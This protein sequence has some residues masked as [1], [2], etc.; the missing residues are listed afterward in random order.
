[1]KKLTKLLSVFVISG[2]VGTSVVA[3]ACNT[4]THNYTYE[5]NGNG[6]HT[7]TCVD[8]DDTIPD[9]LHVDGDSDNKCDNCGA[10]IKEQGTT[11]VVEDKVTGVSISGGKE[12]A[13]KGTLQLTAT[14][15]VTG[16]AATT[17]TW[18]S[19]DEDTA[20]VDANGLVTGVKEGEVTITATSIDDNTKKAEHK[21][22]VK[23]EGTVIVPPGPVITIP[24]YADLIARE[25]VRVK[26]DAEAE[27]GTSLETFDAA[28]SP[29]GLYISGET[30]YKNAHIDYV[31]EGGVKVL[32]QYT[33]YVDSKNKDKNV[34]TVV[35]PGAVKQV[36]EGYFETKVSEYGSSQDLVTFYCGDKTVKIAS[37]GKDTAS[38][39]VTGATEAAAPVTGV[40][41]TKDD[42][43]KVYFKFDLDTGKTTFQINDVSVLSEV[44]T[45]IK[46]FKYLQLVTSNGG[47]RKHTSKNIVI[48]GAVKT[49]EDSKTEANGIIDAELEKYDVTEYTTNGA[50]LTAAVA[51]GKAAVEAAEDVAGI[52]QAVAD[53]KAALKA[54][55]KDSAIAEARTAALD[56]LK[57]KYPSTQFTNTGLEGDDADYN[58]ASLYSDKITE[59]EGALADLNTTAEM[60]AVTDAADEYLAEKTNAKMLAAKKVA[61]VAALEEDA[62][63]YKG[64]LGE[65]E[66]KLAAVDSALVI[67][68]GVLN[69]STS[70]T[71]AN[72]KLEAAKAAL[73]KAV[74]DLDKAYDDVVLEAYE[75]IDNCRAD[76]IADIGSGYGEYDTLI[77]AAKDAAKAKIEAVE[78][79][80]TQA[81]RDLIASTLTDIE[82]EVD[83]Y[84]ANYA[85]HVNA[86]A[87]L[88]EQEENVKNDDA[89]ES[90]YEIDFADLFNEATNENRADKIEAATKRVDDFIASL[91]TLKIAV[92]LDNGEV[93]Y[94]TYGNK[95]TLADLHI[96]GFN[97]TAATV[98]G[99]S[100]EEA[101]LTVYNPVTNVVVTGKT[102]IAGFKV[103]ETWTVAAGATDVAN[104]TENNLY[105][106][107]SKDVATESSTNTAEYFTLASAKAVGGESFTNSWRSSN[108]SAGTDSS[109]RPIIVELKAS[110]SEFAIYLNVSES[111]GVKENRYGTIYCV[112]N[113]D[114]ENPTVVKTLSSSGDMTVKYVVNDL[115][116]GDILEFYLAIPS[117]GSGSRLFLFKTDATVDTSKIEKTVTVN[118]LDSDTDA[119]ISGFDAETSYH[120]FATLT[121]PTA[122]TVAGKSFKHWS[123]TKNGE[124]PY[125][126]GGSL[127]DKTTVTLYAVFETADATLTF[128]G[129]D[130]AV[131]GSAVPV[132]SG[133]AFDVSKAPSAPTKADSEDGKYK[134]EFKGWATRAADPEHEG[135]YIYTL[136]DGTYTVGT[137]NTDLYAQYEQKSKAVTYSVDNKGLGTASTDAITVTG[138]LNEGKSKWTGTIDGIT[139]EGGVTTFE[140]AIRAGG[141]SGRSLKIHLE[142]G[143]KI[144]I[145]CGG[146]YG[147]NGA[148]GDI[149]IGN[150]ASTAS[151]SALAK[152]TATNDSGAKTSSS[153]LEYTATESG[154]YHI[155]FGSGKPSIYA[156]IVH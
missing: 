127:E 35:N 14:V 58:N 74:S 95:L 107:T 121:E 123:E 82:A 27:V 77:T 137:G 55:L 148:S 46:T 99:V 105:K 6:T 54:V 64:T 33:G 113:G 150:S 104:I 101:D 144:S 135:E 120:Y 93:C 67:Q 50:D 23:P 153:L 29:A 133:S 26:I 57:A 65:D 28:N 19:S 15:T 17:V 31:E 20:T 114:T 156:I 97:V 21:I 73:R 106:V 45:G 111:A 9:Q 16:N 86:D 83:R 39:S 126:F 7:A 72:T 125:T 69:G 51:A 34:Y 122:P 149:W 75:G 42:Y 119:A 85:A 4:H 124:T 76:E 62:T 66:T 109:A 48:C 61:V 84:L 140:G 100:V 146:N 68:K 81:N 89:L 132:V 136:V 24:S 11:P 94:V 103:K 40:S 12:V 38:L 134:Y 18:S 36:V 116:A 118:W 145:A 41:V 22:T 70:I 142:A 152:V 2:A 43:I 63:T 155:I 30:G 143:Q 128:H 47:G 56:A 10:T 87:Y 13:E 115:N 3:A 96:S 90:Y 79:E 129:E 59:V 91:A 112:K 78:N 71:D 92:T 102:P 37:T 139:P 32:Q 117:G 25:D 138:G 44:E 52:D 108:V 88:E 131:I 80:D 147:S 5:D 154:D 1:M 60:K 141:D 151:G 98:G 130:G 53:C 49:L 110:L 8:G